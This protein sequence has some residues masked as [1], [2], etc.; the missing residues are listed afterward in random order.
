MGYNNITTMDISEI[1]R[2]K[3]HGEKISSI[4]KSLGYDRKTVRKYTK[5]IEENPD[6]EPATI[7]AK[8]IKNE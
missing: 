1:K 7:T 3:D 2:R 8:L 4:A 6:L 5:L